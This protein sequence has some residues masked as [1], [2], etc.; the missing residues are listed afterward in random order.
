MR[1]RLSLA[2]V[3]CGTYTAESDE[4]LAALTDPEYISRSTAEQLQMRA[5]QFADGSDQR[6]HL[7]RIIV[8]CLRVRQRPVA[9]DLAIARIG[10]V[11]PAAVGAA[12]LTAD[13]RKVNDHASEWA[14]VPICVQV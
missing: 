3:G 4:L 9:L 14:S 10:R 6:L 2:A 8:S 5:V 12:G 13:G 11:E 1:S 7:R